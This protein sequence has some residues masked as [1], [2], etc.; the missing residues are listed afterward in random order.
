VVLI[1]A[2]PEG[3][4]E[5]GR[6][7]QPARSRDNSWAQPVVAGGRLFIRDHDVLLCYD[8]KGKAVASAEK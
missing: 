8:V 4:K 7:D 6:F 2:S 1:E 3:W 5:T